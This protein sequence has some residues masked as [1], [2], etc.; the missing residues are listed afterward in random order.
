MI[1]I[2]LLTQAKKVNNYAENATGGGLW[3]STSNYRAV[4]PSLKRWFLYGGFTIR[5]ASATM[6][7]FIYDASDKYV[8]QLAD[9]AA[10]AGAAYYPESANTGTCL[11]P[12]VMDAGEYISLVFGAAQG[13]GASANCVVLEVDV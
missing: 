5:D 4:V 2:G 12:W 3:V 9:W 11:F 6:K 10:A 13:A 7:A 8:L 1:S